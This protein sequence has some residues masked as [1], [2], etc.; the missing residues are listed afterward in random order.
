LR[1]VSLESN[2]YQLASSEAAASDVTATI[3]LPVSPHSEAA[4]FVWVG[5]FN[6]LVRVQLVLTRV[7]HGS[8][9]PLQSYTQAVP[10]TMPVHSFQFDLSWSSCHF[11]LHKPID[12]V[13]KPVWRS[14][15][16]TGSPLAD[17]CTF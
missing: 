7:L 13:K 8:L 12:S 11:I 9:Q 10:H 6:I 1:Q 3:L 15:L 17:I 4:R 5:V 14:S 16:T 2:C